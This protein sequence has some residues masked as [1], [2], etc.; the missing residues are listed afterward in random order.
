MPEPM[1]HCHSLG[2][3]Y[4]GCGPGI[5]ALADVNFTVHQAE[6]VSIVGPSGCGKTT[7]LRVLAG[8]LPPTE[9]SVSFNRAPVESAVVFQEKSLFPW[10]TAIENAAFSL[11]MKN[12]PRAQR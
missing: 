2:V 6:F 8:L 7:L 10:M 3:V 4:P 12:V 5:P 11:E 1:L 9:G